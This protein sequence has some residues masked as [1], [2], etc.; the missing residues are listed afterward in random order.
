MNTSI[1]ES[2]IFIQIRRIL[3]NF[4]GTKYKKKKLFQGETAE[5]QTIPRKSSRAEPVHK[6]EIVLYARL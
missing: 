3:Y 2:Y 6:R 4:S 1:S 5:F